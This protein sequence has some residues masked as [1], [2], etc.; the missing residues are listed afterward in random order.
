MSS[1]LISILVTL[2]VIVAIMGVG[3]ILHALLADRSRGRRRCAGCWYTMDGT[4]GLVC[5]ECGR[6]VADEAGLLRTRP[7][8][9]RAVCGGVVVLLGAALAGTPRVVAGGWYAT[10]PTSALVFL[11]P[12]VGEEAAYTAKHG[13]GSVHP[14]ASELKKRFDEHGF[15]TSEWTTLLERSRV[16]HARER[17]PVDHGV[18]VALSESS[19]LATCIMNAEVAT[20]DCSV[21]RETMFDADPFGWYATLGEAAALPPGEL[22]S[23][24]VDMTVPLSGSQEGDTDPVVSV[25]VPMGEPARGA[26]ALRGVDTPELAAAVRAALRLRLV[27]LNFG[28]EPYFALEIELDVDRL[29]ARAKKMGFD[30]AVSCHRRDGTRGV[31]WKRYAAKWMRPGDPVF[32]HSYQLTP[33]DVADP[34]ERARWEVVVRGVPEKGVPRAFW[35]G[36]VVVPLNEIGAWEPRRVGVP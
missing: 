21:V 6:E 18:V 4:P 12:T 34:A 31:R 19:W 28:W 11:T 32:F 20:A 24:R 17:W 23:V 3:L 26:Y 33:E 14:I 5:P 13:P 35:S 22:A 1:P 27:S 36:E 16:L 10:L 29:G 2:G 8:W 25:R 9:R 15:T 30:V 7:H